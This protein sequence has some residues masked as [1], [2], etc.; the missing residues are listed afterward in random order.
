MIQYQIQVDYQFNEKDAE[1]ISR[2]LGEFN[3]PFFGNQKTIHCLICLK[4]D[5]QNVVGGVIAWM[6]PGIGLLCVDTIWVS[7]PLRKQGYGK[8]LMLAVEAEGIKHHCT[9]SQLE[10]LSFQSKEFY[11]KLGYVQIGFV[12]KLYGN[13]DAIYMRKGL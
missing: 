2:G 10:T 9:H 3:G 7:E 8:K 1:A 5:C 4:D 6:R 11:Q 13:H 12:E